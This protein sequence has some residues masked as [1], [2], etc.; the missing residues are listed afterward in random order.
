MLCLCG[1][2]L[3]SGWVPLRDDR[4]IESLVTVRLTNGAFHIPS[5]EHCIRFYSKEKK[6]SFADFFT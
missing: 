4:L 6:T 3:Y 5:K 2:E 1:F